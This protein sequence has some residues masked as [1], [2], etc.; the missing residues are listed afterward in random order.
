[1]L[2][3]APVFAFVLLASMHAAHA[4]LRTP[5]RKLQSLRSARRE[6]EEQMD[7][8][9]R[10]AASADAVSIC[11]GVVGAEVTT[12]PRPSEQRDAA[13]RGSQPLRSLV[14][15]SRPTA[16]AGS[17]RPDVPE[18]MWGPRDLRRVDEALV[19]ILRLDLAPDA[20][21][22]AE[23]VAAKVHA[24]IAAVAAGSNLTSAAKHAKV[25]EALGDMA[26][27]EVALSKPPSVP[28]LA[29]RNPS[30]VAGDKDHAWEFKSR[31]HLRAEA[32]E[33]TD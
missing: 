18:G 1:M 11:Q 7:A 10:G 27:L 26:L 23:K 13:F 31:G 16:C 21:R 5:K 22:I 33:R 3:L 25:G 17:A 19:H 9:E 4:H 24:Q 15:T 8:A 20:R 32:A 28:E 6:A 14:T 12:P 29:E 30:L 2:R